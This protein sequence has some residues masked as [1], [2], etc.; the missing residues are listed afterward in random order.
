MPWLA[1][2][3]LLHLQM[4]QDLRGRFAPAAAWL[5]IA[6]FVLTLIGTFLVRSGVLTSV[7]AFAS[8]PRRG[9]VMLAMIAAA[10][11]A[12]F[13]LWA[14]HAAPGS[15]G[16][17][18]GRG[19]AVARHG[20]GAQQPAAG[21]GLRQRAARHAHPLAMDALG[22]GKLSVGAPYFDAVMAP[23]LL[24]ALA[25]LLPAAGLRWGAE[26]PALWRRLRPT[27]VALALGA[28]LLPVLLMQ[29]HGRIVRGT[30][31]AL[32]LAL[33]VAASTLDAAVRRLRESGPGGFGAWP[34]AHGAGAPGRGRVRRRRRDGQGL[35]H[36]ARRAPGARRDAPPG[37]L[38][39]AL[40]AARPAGRPE[41]QRTGRPA[42]ASTAPTSRRARC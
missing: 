42:S 23:L 39:A 31:L 14:R 12:S 30:A 19:A 4:V 20:A 35:R 7:H 34:P 36:R 27:V 6:G 11:L 1:L 21:R 16:A 40:R 38:P 25:L 13:G 9:S 10:M 5:S 33:G 32:W 22:L 18:A 26:V 37:R 28:G 24:P 2:A 8:D 29:A 15:A 17:R 3:A 41:L